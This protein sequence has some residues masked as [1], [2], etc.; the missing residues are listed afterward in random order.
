MDAR[1]KYGSGDQKKVQNVNK[2]MEEDEYR[3]YKYKKTT[4]ERKENCTVN[5]RKE[6]LVLYNIGN[7]KYN[8]QTEDLKVINI[9]GAN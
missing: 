7:G 2:N 5:A 8:K 3:N 9:G 6:I 4:Q 1:K